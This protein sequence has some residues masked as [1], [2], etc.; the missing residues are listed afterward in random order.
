MFRPILLFTISSCSSSSFW[1][2]YLILL[3]ICVGSSSSEFYVPHML[4]SP[5]LI[6]SINF[7]SS[8]VGGRLD[9][10]SSS[11]AIDFLEP[12]YNLDRPW[13][14][15]TFLLLTSE[16]PK[17]PSLCSCK[18]LAALLILWDYWSLSLRDPEAVLGSLFLLLYM[19]VAALWIS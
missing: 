18:M 1:V 17:A 3:R 19:A 10:F 13:C 6:A 7:I 12:L 14:W 9:A 5:R 15:E 11:K 2:S 4:K 8:R 16:L